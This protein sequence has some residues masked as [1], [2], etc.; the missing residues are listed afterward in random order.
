MQKPHLPVRA[1]KLF[2]LIWGSIEPR[3]EIY[4]HSGLPISMVPCLHQSN[5]NIKRKLTVWRARKCIPLIGAE[6]ALTCTGLQ[7]TPVHG[8][9]YSAENGN[10]RKFRSIYRHG[11]MFVPKQYLYQKKA[12]GMESPKMYSTRL[13]WNRTY[14]YWPANYP[15]TWREV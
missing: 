11:T 7:T 6:T 5:V 13:C 10:L 15:D 2:H 8:G 14:L 1:Y 4:V 12:K 3:M 9:K